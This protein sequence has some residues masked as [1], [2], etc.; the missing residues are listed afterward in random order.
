MDA[1]QIFDVHSC[2]LARMMTA[3]ATS[4]PEHADEDLATV[5][6]LVCHGSLTYSWAT[7]TTTP[8]TPTPQWPSTVVVI[9]IVVPF[10]GEYRPVGRPAVA[11]IPASTT[12]QSPTAVYRRK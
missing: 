8:R 9:V 3:A 5:A 4:C 7:T 2:L 12:L 10:Y 1:L 11:P 6:L